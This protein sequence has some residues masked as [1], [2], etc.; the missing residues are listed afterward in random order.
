MSDETAKP[1]KAVP[2]TDPAQVG[3][4]ALP[5][6]VL[7]DSTP[8]HG[9]TLL[10]D[11]LFLKLDSQQTG[12]SVLPADALGSDIP[13]PNLALGESTLASNITP[14]RGSSVLMGDAMKAMPQISTPILPKMVE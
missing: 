12:T 14:Q 10:D 1:K 5:G 3:T 2:G 8:Q 7:P 11:S 9:T 6:S 4:S 13:P